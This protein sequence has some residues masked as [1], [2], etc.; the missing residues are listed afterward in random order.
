MERELVKLEILTNTFKKMKT[1]I[2]MLTL[3]LISNLAIGKTHKSYAQ[4]KLQA[5]SIKPAQT[6]KFKPVN[7]G[8]KKLHPTNKAILNAIIINGI[9]WTTTTILRH[10]NPELGQLPTLGGW[11]SIIGCSIN[12]NNKINKYGKPKRY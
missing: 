5:A 6:I 8:K 2:F 1:I 10:T 11:V 9:T 12:V 4:F 7:Y 3:L